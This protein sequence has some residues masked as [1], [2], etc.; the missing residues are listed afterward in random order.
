MKNSQMRNRSVTTLNDV[1]AEAGVSKSTVSRVLNNRLGNGF[2][3]TEEVRKRVLAAAEKL[4]YHPNLI[5][6]SLTLQTTRMIHIIGGHYA[7][8]DLGNI[9]QTVVNSATC[10]MDCSG[11]VFDVTVDMSQHDQQSSELPPWKIDGAIILARANSFTLRELE[12]S[13][14]PYVVVNGPAGK[15]GSSVVPDDECGTRMAIQYLA[16]LGHRIIAYANSRPDYLVG[17]S[18]LADRHQTYLREM[19]K[20]GLSVAPGH[21]EWLKSAE[22]FLTAAV[23]ENGATAVLAYGYMEGLNLM[24]A[25]HKLGITVPG[26][27]S[28]LCFCDQQ[29]ATAMSPLFSFIDLRSSDMG[30]IAAELLLKHIKRPGNVEPATIK[31]A[32]QLVIRGSTAPPE[33]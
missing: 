25:A 12:D 31:L 13:Q 32:E 24:Q 29:A 11:D 15:S 16:E 28:V 18:S 10:V 14:I 5:A 2:S 23:I 30:R 17:H 4:N 20:L 1:A 26:R 19:K 6:K 9:Y 22:E 33:K 27:L 8:S 7:L 3:V 21:D